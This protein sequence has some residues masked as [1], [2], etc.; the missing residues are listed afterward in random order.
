MQFVFHG[1]LEELKETL[2]RKAKETNKELMIDVKDPSVL[3]IGFHRLSHNGGRF[4]IASVS[5]EADKVL[6]DGEIKDVFSHQK[7]SKLGRIWNELTEYLAAYL[8]LVVLL[9]LPWLLLKALIPLWI[10]LLLPLFWLILR[11]F[12]NKRYEDR[13]DKEFTE[14]LSFCT[15]YPTDKGNW[16]DV[17]Q[18]LDLATGKLYP[19]FDDEEDML[20]IRYEDGMLIDVGYVKEEKAYYVTVVKEDSAEAWSKPLGVFSTVDKHK[21]PT[22]LQKAIHRF[23]GR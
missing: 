10:P 22:E 18:R 23:R 1:T 11:R 16:Y 13:L 19:I 21:L 17:Y 3:E 8:F 5:E 2:R 4:F 7:K 9:L 15:L 14:F 6:L 12:L 20:C